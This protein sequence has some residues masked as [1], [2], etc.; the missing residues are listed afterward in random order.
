MKIEQ[1]VCSLIQAKKLNELGI[2][3]YKSL[4]RWCVFCPDPLGET[5]YYEPVFWDDNSGM[6]GE[7]IA[8]AFTISE[9]GRMLSKWIVDD[10]DETP[11]IVTD[12]YSKD[13]SNLY[14]PKLHADIL[15]WN[16]ENNKITASDCN[17]ALLA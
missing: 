4:F 10:N 2:E 6:P 3:Q 12:K 8:D 11:N 16:L 5:H 15:I 17:K 13:M 7:F 9:I 1:Q 14:N